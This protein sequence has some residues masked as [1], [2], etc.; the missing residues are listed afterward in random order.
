MNA[1]PTKRRVLGSL[2]LNITRSPRSPSSS[3][4]AANKG[5]AGLGGSPLKK[6]TGNSHSLSRHGTPSPSRKRTTPTKRPLF[7]VLSDEKEN[8]DVLPPAAKKLCSDTKILGGDVSRTKM[9]VENADEVDFF[10][11]LSIIW[12]S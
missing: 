4:L 9:T 12:W 6:K 2:D 11:F 8:A 7:S 1:T 5:L 3:K 10:F